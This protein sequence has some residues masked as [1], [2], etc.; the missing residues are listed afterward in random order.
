MRRGGDDGVIEEGNARAGSGADDGP[1]LTRR[2]GRF[3]ERVMRDSVRLDVRPSA[4]LPSL[5]E[6]RQRD[7]QLRHHRQR[8][9]EGVAD[10]LE[11]TERGGNEHL[12]TIRMR[13][14]GCYLFWIQPSS[15]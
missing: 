9:E 10:S 7:R 2:A 6:R 8:G 11:P 3:A 15:S 4:L 1:S 14:L 5:V 13:T 12:L